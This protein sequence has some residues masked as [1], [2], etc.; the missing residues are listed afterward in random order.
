MFYG[1]VPQQSEGSVLPKNLLD[2]GFGKFKG[3]IRV[4]KK[5]KMTDFQ[6]EIEKFKSK[7]SKIMAELKNVEKYEKLTKSILVKHEV[8]IRVYIL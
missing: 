6:N 7:D 2:K 8:I 4:C 3:V 5:Q 1:S